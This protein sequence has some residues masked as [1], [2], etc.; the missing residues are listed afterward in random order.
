[1]AKPRV[2]NSCGRAATKNAH[3]K[4]HFDTTLI[5]FLMIILS[6]KKIDF[7]NCR[8]DLFIFHVEIF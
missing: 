7:Y 8:S 5:F 3:K 1:V 6:S 2:Q 4:I